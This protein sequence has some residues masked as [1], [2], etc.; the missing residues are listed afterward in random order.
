MMY[1]IGFFILSI[2]FG[3][4]NGNTSNSKADKKA[5]GDY[6]KNNKRKT[7]KAPWDL[8]KKTSPLPSL[9]HLDR[10][11]GKSNRYRDRSQG[12]NR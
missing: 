7:L 4:Y 11:N 9:H 1:D 8:N 10:C 2:C 6:Y 3:V 12:R 5:D